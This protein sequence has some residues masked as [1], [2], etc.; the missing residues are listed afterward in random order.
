MFNAEY[1]V[2]NTFHYPI[3]VNGKLRLTLEL[4]L[5]LAQADVEKAVMQHEVVQKWIEG[6]EPKKIVFVKGK[7]VNVVV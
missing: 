3:S 5:D 4:A 6:K 2:E 1:L 7:I